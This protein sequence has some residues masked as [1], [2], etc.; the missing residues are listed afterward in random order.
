MNVDKIIKKLGETPDLSSALGIEFIS[1]PEDDTCMARMH[2]DS[3]NRQPFGFL[4]GGASMAMAEHLA[5][6]GSL[7]LCPDKICMGINVNGEHVMAVTEGETV[8]AIARLKHKGCTL[9][10]WSVEIKNEMGSL[11]SLINVTNY[12]INKPK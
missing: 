3:R 8:T 7:A 9:H 6:V 12:I 1:T 10:V 11:V 2:V 4:S 5:G